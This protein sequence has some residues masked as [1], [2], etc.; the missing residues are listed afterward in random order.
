MSVVRDAELKLREMIEQATREQRYADIAA[1]AAI[2]EGLSRVSPRRRE[3]E[4]PAAVRAD[5]SR[6]LNGS[7]GS[8]AKASTGSKKQFPRFEREGDRLIKI[9]WSKKGKT[10]YEH[11]APREAVV[12]FVRHLTSRVKLGQVFAV[13]DLLPSP[14]AGGGELP[15]YQVYLTLA[16]LRRSGAIE[17]KGRNGYVLRSDLLMDGDLNE[18]WDA[19]PTRS[20]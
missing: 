19:L 18:L 15:A 5:N 2:A 13:E 4:R 16:W 3:I 12:A 14:D 7:R 11:R 20:A 8:V 17:K 1:V 6:L 10:E 9:G